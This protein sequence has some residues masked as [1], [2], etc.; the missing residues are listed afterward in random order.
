MSVPNF[1]D[2]AKPANDLLNKDFY[3]LSAGTLE[4]KSN[5]PNNVAFKVNGKNSHEKTTTG[6]SLQNL[7]VVLSRIG[8]STSGLPVEA[9]IALSPKVSTLLM[10]YRRTG[11]TV[12]QTWNTANALESKLELA[13]SLAKGL[14]AEGVFSFLPATQARGAKF[15][16]HFKQ[17]SFHGR[18]FFD[19]LKG[20]T[21]NVDA[22]IGHDGFL[23]G[24]SAGYDVNKA[25]V[26]S[27]SAAVGYQAPTY[28]A[29]VTASDNLSI[30]AASYHHKVNSQVEAAAK[31]IWNSK[32][33]NA[34]GLE[35]ATKYRLDPLS[36]VKAKINDRGVAAVAYNVLLREGVTFGIGASFD[37]QKLDQ[38]TH[39]VG[40]SFTFEA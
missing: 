7:S 6:T 33:G 22:V 29:A 16:L 18:A 36:F 20:P 10:F 38:A 24:A 21:A 35:V 28:S 9:A 2:I 39:K 4:V 8:G 14:K 1:S 26:T 13:D 30:F 31:A 34:V 11:L 37:T 3:H 19:L 25:A 5:T 40:T 15:N 12:T 23:A 27:Y 32:S 17:S